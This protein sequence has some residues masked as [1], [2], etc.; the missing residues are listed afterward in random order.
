MAIEKDI[1]Q[2]LAV[3]VEEMMENDGDKLM[4]IYELA[5]VMREFPNDSLFLNVYV[6][7]FQAVVAWQKEELR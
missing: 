2:W 4:Q 5:Q 3:V 7:C 6:G 1:D